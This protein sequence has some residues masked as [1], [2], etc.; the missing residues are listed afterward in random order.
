MNKRDNLKLLNFAQIKLRQK[1]SKNKRARMQGPQK[2]TRQKYTST[3]THAHTY[4]AEQTNYV[5]GKRSCGG[6][7]RSVLSRLACACADMLWSMSMGAGAC[8]GAAGSSESA[9]FVW[10][11]I[12]KLDK[13]LTQYPHMHAHA[14]LLFHLQDMCTRIHNMYVPTSV[15]YDALILK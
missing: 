4:R 11:Q 9:C 7:L 6:L 3:H 12:G 14:H 10:L 1:I 8:V 13:R 15:F 5:L 2:Y